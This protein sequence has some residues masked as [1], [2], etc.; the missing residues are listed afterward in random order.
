MGPRD[1]FMRTVRGRLNVLGAAHE[2][3]ADGDAAAGAAPVAAS[4]KG[5]PPEAAEHTL[6]A[7]P[8]GARGTAGYEAWKAGKHG[9][10]KDIMAHLSAFGGA[11]AALPPTR[12]A[13]RAAPATRGSASPGSPPAFPSGMGA[14]FG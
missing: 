11:P 7:A 13:P 9:A 6:H 5:R 8:T 4:P 2:L 10:L 1:F 14:D 3:A 12:A